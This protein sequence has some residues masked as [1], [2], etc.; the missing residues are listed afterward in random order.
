MMFKSIVTMYKS[1][2]M[3]K[4]TTQISVNVKVLLDLT[5]NNVKE[6]V[7]REVNVELKS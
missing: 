1:S 3:Y 2:K 4:S 6:S 5:S 7:K